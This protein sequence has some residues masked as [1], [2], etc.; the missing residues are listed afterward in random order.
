[1]NKAAHVCGKGYSVMALVAPAISRESIPLTHVRAL[2]MLISLGGPSLTI[3]ELS[4]RCASSAVRVVWCHGC[5]LAIDLPCG[6]MA[7]HD[8]AACLLVLSRLA[9]ASRRPWRWTVAFAT[10]SLRASYAGQKAACDACDSIA[11]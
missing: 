10:E 1:M 4:V 11:R 5:V 2:H 3:Y 9:P 6:K 7:V 8:I